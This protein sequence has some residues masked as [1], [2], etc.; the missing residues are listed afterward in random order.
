MEHLQISYGNLASESDYGNILNTNELVNRIY[1]ADALSFLKRI[2]NNSID[3]I[4]T[5]PPYYQQRNYGYGG[6]GNENT[7]AE[8]ISNL[9]SVFTEC[10]RIIKATGA[11]VFNI[12]DKYINGNLSLIPYKFALRVL[13]DKKVFLINQITWAKTNPTPRQEQRKLIQSTEPFFVFAKTK[14]YC[15]KLDEYLMHL[16]RKIKK[17]T[18]FFSKIG[19]KYFNVIKLSNLT[20]QEKEHAKQE[21]EKA[22]E[23]VKLGKIESFRMKIRGIHKEAYGGMEGGRNNQIRRNGFT[24][25]KITGNAMKKDL[26]ESPVEITKD[27]KHLAVYP[28]YIIQELV[29]LLSNND[30]IVLDPFCGSGTTCIAAKNLGRKYL[31]IEINPEYVALSEKRIK[32]VYNYEEFFL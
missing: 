31:G 23:E 7:E 5:S 3:L 19:Q 27:N 1:C 10:S 21:L 17:T 12:G 18:S 20:M 22:I 14:N 13:E 8:Y 4:I 6:I 16:N 29:K 25:I 32:K 26:I 11:I 9:L 2:A 24:I 28:L 15:F 30:D